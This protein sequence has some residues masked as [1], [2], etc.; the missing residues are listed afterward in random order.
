MD[1]SVIG[2]IGYVY[3][4][5]LLFRAGVSPFTPGRDVPRS[6]LL[7]LWRDARKLLREGER[8]GRIVTHRPRDRYAYHCTGRP[9]RVCA[10]PIEAGPLAN[11]TV[12]WCPQCQPGSRRLE[13]LPLKA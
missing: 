7:A 8:T 5:E 11:R 10:T 2:G 6:K 12:Y 3:R 9:C 4:S 1:Q 13:R